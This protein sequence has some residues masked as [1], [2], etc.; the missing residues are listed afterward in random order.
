MSGTPPHPVLPA[1]YRSE[2]ERRPFVT[3]LFDGTARYYDLVCGLGSLGSGQLYRRW[4]LRRAGLRPGMRLLDVGTGTGLVARAAAQ[5]LGDSRAVVGLDPSAGMLQQARL[6]LPGPLVQ[7]LA[8]ALP[9]AGD[10]FDA[11][12]MGY[13]LRHV[14]DLG[15]AFTEF[16]RVLRPGGRLLILEITPPRSRLGRR[17]LEGYLGRLLPRATR[18]GTGSARAEMLVRYYW[19]TIAEC[20][21]PE[22]ILETLSGSG[23]V[24]V[25]RRVYG[26]LLSEYFARKP[27][28]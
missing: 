7:G 19:D 20:V 22:T 13:A 18:L 21:P 5:I 8:E 9:F 12:S 2:R 27:A 6:R 4:V 15:V 3:S 28:P 25:E 24:E 17:L 14:A 11:L 16:R 10:R 26:G 1:Y 23:F